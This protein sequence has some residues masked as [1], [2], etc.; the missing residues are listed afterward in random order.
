MNAY[1]IDLKSLSVVINMSE[2]ML[3]LVFRSKIC[4]CGVLFDSSSLPVLSLLC[5]FMNQ[6]C[7]FSSILAYACLSCFSFLVAIM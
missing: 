3:L 4:Q 7:S 1:M 6:V 2:V 5:T